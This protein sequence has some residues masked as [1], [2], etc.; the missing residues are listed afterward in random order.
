MRSH[1]MIP[2]Y[3][4]GSSLRAMLVTGKRYESEMK[5]TK[6]AVAKERLSLIIIITSKFRKRGAH[7]LVVQ[8]IMEDGVSTLLPLY[9]SW[10]HV[11]KTYICSP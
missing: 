11:F 7:R 8:R 2:T 5:Q 4:T 10:G 3:H 6:T 9:D 1:D